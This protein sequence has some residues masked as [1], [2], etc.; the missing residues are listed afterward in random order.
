[1]ASDGAPRYEISGDLTISTL[2]GS[3]SLY[4]EAF[5]KA[6]FVEVKASWSHTF[7]SWTGLEWTKNLFKKSGGF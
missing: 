2:S 1:M 4:A 3:L 7:F 6:W 5:V